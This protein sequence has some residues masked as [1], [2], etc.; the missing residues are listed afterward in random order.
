MIIKM[1]GTALPDK[2]KIALLAN[3]AVGLDIA[4]YL[5]ERKENI[6]VLV[7]HPVNS[8]KLINEIKNIF[9]GVKTYESSDLTRADVLDKLRSMN[10]DIAVSAWFGF[11]LKKP[12]IDLF[13]Y[14]CV[15]LHNSLLPQGR[16]KYPH[17]WAIYGEEPY[18]V[19]IHYIDEG[20]DSGDIIAQREVPIKE[21]DIAGTLYSR[22]LED[23]ATLFKETW[24]KIKNGEICPRPQND[25]DALSH[26]SHEAVK[27]DIIDLDKAYRGKELINRLRARSFQ[28]R[29]YAYY[30]KNGKKI[31]VKIEL[32]ENPNF[33]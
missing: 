15:N 8:G 31:Y 21:T 4:K 27:L 33:K 22:S 32:S 11:I 18:G 25:V 12:F 17:V 2:P 20:I 9:P 28:D 14:G 24:P 16:G 29:T 3:D 7:V 10:L 1:R 13:L 5:K 6:A 19:T 26:Y 30:E 23:V